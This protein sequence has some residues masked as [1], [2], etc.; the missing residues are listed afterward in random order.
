MRPLEGYRV[1]ELGI[2]VA[3]PA[4][5]SM[6]GEWGAD[7]VKVESPGGDPNRFTLRHVGVDAARSP[8]F[9]LDNRDKRGVVLDLKH[10]VTAHGSRGS[11]PMRTSSSPT[12]APARSSGSG[13]IPKPCGC[14]SPG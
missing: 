1:V 14:G 11:S 10:E 4:A 7:V 12:C 5:A 9:D 6:L 3:G 2:W 8:A 13:S